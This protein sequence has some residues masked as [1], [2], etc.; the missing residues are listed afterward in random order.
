MS[1]LGLILLLVM[2]T[3]IPPTSVFKTCSELKPWN[4]GATITAVMMFLIFFVCPHQFRF[5]NVCGTS[6]KCLPLHYQIVTL[7]LLKRF[8]DFFSKLQ[9]QNW[10]KSLTERHGLSVK[11]QKRPLSLSSIQFHIYRTLTCP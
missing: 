8:G 2:I 9:H 6:R 4:Q 5:S 11:M 1:C 3:A 7:K 10:S